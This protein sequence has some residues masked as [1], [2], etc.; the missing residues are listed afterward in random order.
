MN[1]KK[2]K[3]NKSLASQ[4]LT[5]YSNCV[6]ERVSDLSS[7]VYCHRFSLTELKL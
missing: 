6:E 3:Q 7:F 2:T 5:L 4:D 1:N